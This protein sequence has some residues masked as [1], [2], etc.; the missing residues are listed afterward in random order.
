MISKYNKFLKEKQMRDIL[1][2]LDTLNEATN[3]APSELTDPNRFEKFLWKIAN[4]DPFLNKER[5]QVFLD[6][7]EAER[8]R[9]LRDA[10]MF[11]GGL[12]ARIANSNN[13]IA[14]SQ[15]LKTNDLGGQQGDPRKPGEADVA[16]TDAGKESLLVKP[17]TIQITDF[18]IPAGDLYKVIT[19]NQILNSTEYG[20][21]VI[22]LANEIVAGQAVVLPPEYQ[23]KSMEKVRK[24]IVD[25]AG[26]YLGVLALV[27]GRTKFDNQKEFTKWLGAGV[28]ELVV[29]FP[30][31]SNTNI[32]DS[33]ATVKNKKTSH[34]LNISSKGTGG[35]AAPAISGLKISDDIKRN[36]NLKNAVKFIE[37]CQAKADARGASTLIQAF[38]AMNF[39]YSIN[40]SAISKK[41]HKFLLWQPAAIATIVDAVS[42]GAELPKKY[43][44]LFSDIK[45]RG[46]KVTEGGTLV[47][48]IKKDVAEAIN[49]RDAIPEFKDTIL[50][51][52]EMNFIQQYTD[53]NKGDITF[54]TQWPAKLDGDVSVVNKSSAAEPTAG[55]FSFKLG[56]VTKDD[57]V[58]GGGTTDA[59]AKLSADDL[60]TKTQKRSGLKASTGGVEKK[61]GSEK[62]LGRKRQR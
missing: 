55:G 34:S 37:L 11:K 30:G 43:S 17:K 48:A 53:Y 19:N 59:P 49:D 15:L 32:A 25:Y 2:L 29:N 3:L 46:G 40:P 31:K 38:E 47:Y 26:E 28:G 42:T 12:K 36:P 56:R 1:N 45:T 60:D 44:P 41:F 16:G 54:E 5:Q 62:T 33:Y 7:A 21:T 20:K 39:I 35:G 24:A 52:L 61:F 6:P 57:E 58:G 9:E 8:F 22:Q 50:Q 10:N 14:L 23:N 18:D 13:E 27:T 4:N 51:V